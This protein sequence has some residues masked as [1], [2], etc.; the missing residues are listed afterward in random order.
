MTVGF[1]LFL[2]SSMISMLS[3][4]SIWRMRDASMCK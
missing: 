4:S 2:R 1:M 3:D